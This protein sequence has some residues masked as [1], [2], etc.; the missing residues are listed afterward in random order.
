MRQ[1]ALDT[2]TTGLSTEQGH[3]IIEIGCVELVD[4][5]LTGN[6][7]HYYFDPERDVDPG[8]FA[9]H[10]ISNSFLKNKP[11]FKSIFSNLLDYI[12]GAELIIHNAPF[13][14]G[15]LNYEFSL[16]G[17]MQTVSKYCAILDTLKLAR[18][19]HPNQKNSLDALCK[20]YEV[21]HSHR[22]LHG[23]LLDANLLARLYLVMTGGQGSLFGESQAESPKAHIETINLLARNKP[24]P[25]IKLSEEEEQAHQDFINLIKTTS[26][27]SLW[28]E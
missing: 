11:K 27:I 16:L 1:I 3:R 5:K 24:L 9:M 4:R 15:F 13:D 6:N 28:E 19:L 21:D 26:G 14:I 22:Q 18:K 23:A 2:E 17:H 12:K 25:V 8:A 10:G 20:R 7:F